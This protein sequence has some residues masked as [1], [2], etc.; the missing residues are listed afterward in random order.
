MVGVVL[1][2]RRCGAV[3]GMTWHAGDTHP[4]LLMLV[5][6]ACGCRV[7]WLAGCCVLWVTWVASGGGVYL[8]VGW[9][10]GTLVVV[11]V[12]VVG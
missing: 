12:V 9:W 8:W 3:G 6:W 4:V 2:R 1:G 11:E 7:C 10:H 5:T